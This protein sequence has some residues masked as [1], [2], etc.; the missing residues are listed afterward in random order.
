MSL[1]F[2]VSTIQLNLQLIFICNREEKDNAAM[3]I[4]YETQTLQSEYCTCIEN[5][6]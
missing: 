5:V 4:S 6:P 3:L 2:L 1:I